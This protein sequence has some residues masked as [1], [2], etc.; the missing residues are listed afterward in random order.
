MRVNKQSPPKGTVQCAPRCA[1]QPTYL[2]AE[3]AGLVVVVGGEFHPERVVRDHRGRPTEHVVHEVQ[4]REVHRQHGD[5]D[6]DDSSNPTKQKKQDNDQSSEENNSNEEDEFNPTLAAMETEIKPKILKTVNNL[7][8]EYNKL[9]KYRLT[10][11]ESPDRK[12]VDE[13]IDFNVLN[14]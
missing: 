9:I 6:N 7:T 4:R 5:N 1:V 13:Y 2:H 3:E 14:Q 12:N 10:V 8:K 11:R